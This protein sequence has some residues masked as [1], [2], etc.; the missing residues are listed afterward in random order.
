MQSRA[1]H[2]HHHRHHQ[3]DSN[4]NSDSSS[5]GQLT[6]TLNDLGQALQSGDLTGAQQAYS[7]FQQEFSQLA[8]LAGSQAAQQVV[9]SSLSLTA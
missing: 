6:S 7:T 1:T 3:S 4:S 8:A 5:G 9:N 2:G